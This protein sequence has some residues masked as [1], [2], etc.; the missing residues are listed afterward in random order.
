MTHMEIIEKL[1]GVISRKPCDCE[2]PASAI[3]TDENLELTCKAVVMLWV[4]K[5]LDNADS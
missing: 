3:C 2:C 5:E 4:E 1:V